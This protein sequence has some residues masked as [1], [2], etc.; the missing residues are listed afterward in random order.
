M[1]VTTEKEGS[2]ERNVYSYH[3]AT[4]VLRINANGTYNWKPMGGTEISGKWTPATDGPG[5]VLLKGYR[6]HNWT[7]RN[8]CTATEV[9]IRKIENA[10]LYPSSSTETSMA[11]KRPIKLKQAIIPIEHIKVWEVS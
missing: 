5:I 7:I 4:D 8:D 10:R 2:Y 11:A 3:S 6:G 9:H 1:A